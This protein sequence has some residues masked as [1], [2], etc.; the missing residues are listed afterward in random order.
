MHGS[1]SLPDRFER[2]R[3]TSR[4]ADAGQGIAALIAAGAPEELTIAARALDRVFL[5]AFYVAPLY[6]SSII[7]P[8]YPRELKR[9][10]SVPKLGISLELWWRG[11]E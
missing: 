4:Y 1:R 10:N 11:G 6:H 5:S 9:P 8:A 2:F 7:S 3:C